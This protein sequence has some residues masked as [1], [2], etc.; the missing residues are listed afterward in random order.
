MT[1]T[2]HTTVAAINIAFSRIHK[3]RP[4][5]ICTR[6]FRII[7]C[8][9]VKLMIVQENL[10]LCKFTIDMIRLSLMYSTYNIRDTV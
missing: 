9:S 6:S 8:I 1:L 7:S 5:T 4:S 2:E 10:W 3:K